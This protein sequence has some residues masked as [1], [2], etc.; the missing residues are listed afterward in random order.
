MHT[1]K[2]KIKIEKHDRER[3]H[4]EESTQ[5]EIAGELWEDRKKSESFTARETT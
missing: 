4:T 3:H 2:T 1:N 5:Q